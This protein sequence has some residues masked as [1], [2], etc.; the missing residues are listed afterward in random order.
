MSNPEQQSAENSLFIL[1]N[2]LQLKWW[3]YPI[4]LPGTYIIKQ[5]LLPLFVHVNHTPGHYWRHSFYSFRL[6]SLSHIL[7]S[8]RETKLFLLPLNINILDRFLFVAALQEN[9]SELSALNSHAE[10]K[11]IFWIFISW[12]M[13]EH[14]HMMMERIVL[15]MLLSATST[16]W[17]ITSHS[18]KAFIE[19]H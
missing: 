4:C 13:S 12:Y 14:W 16:L 1:L 2:L 8:C 19:N 15:N 3:K 11:N 5:P 7:V 17:S 18:S 6:F 9:S 10:W